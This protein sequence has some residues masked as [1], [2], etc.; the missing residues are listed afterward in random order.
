[1]LLMVEGIQIAKGSATIV[2]V[3]QTQA[4]QIFVEKAREAD[5]LLIE[6]GQLRSV[7]KMFRSTITAPSGAF[8]YDLLCKPRTKLSAELPVCEFCTQKGHIQH[9]CMAK[10]LNTH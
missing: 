10:K 8:R 7:L 4:F 1:M 6:E 5:Y 2:E 3:A 9:F